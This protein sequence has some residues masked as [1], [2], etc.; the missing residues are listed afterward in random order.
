MITTSVRTGNCNTT[1]LTSFVI[2]SPTHSQFISFSSCFLG[3]PRE[4]LR[5]L[6]FNDFTFLGPSIRGPVASPL[7]CRMKFQQH[8]HCIV[9][10]ASGQKW[11]RNFETSFYLGRDLTPASRL[12]VQH[13]TTTPSHLY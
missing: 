11:R 9:D 13:A 7:S 10:F 2:P 4:T 6:S 3:E 1:A 5:M 12:T 8:I